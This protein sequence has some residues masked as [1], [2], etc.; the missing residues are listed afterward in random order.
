MPREL[1]Y[2]PK[3]EEDLRDIYLYI[4]ADNPDRAFEF[5]GEI[6]R[7]CATLCELPELGPARPRLGT[8]LRIYPIRRRVVVIYRLIDTA[9]E[10]VRT[11]YG[12]R[13][14]EALLASAE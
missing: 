8:G 6:R 7:R 12:G 3:A 13:D 4:A 11:A 5:V 14:I 9:I 2:R 1:I 10:I